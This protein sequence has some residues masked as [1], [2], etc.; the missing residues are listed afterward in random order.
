MWHSEQGQ[1]S[2]TQL[3]AESFPPAVIDLVISSTLKK[4]PFHFCPSLPYFFPSLYAELLLRV[5]LLSLFLDPPPKLDL[6]PPSP[7]PKTALTE[8]SKLEI[9]QLA[10]DFS[11]LAPQQL[12]TLPLDLFLLLP[13]CYPSTPGFQDYA[14]SLFPLLQVF[15]SLLGLFTLKCSRTQISD[16]ASFLYDFVSFDHI[17]SSWL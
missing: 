15:P 17:L 2:P 16:C 11:I 8:V 10:A 4:P 13:P 1:Q 6:T 9:L 5:E 3:S 7:T 12:L 14:C